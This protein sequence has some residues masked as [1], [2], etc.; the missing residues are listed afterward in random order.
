MKKLKIAIFDVNQTIFNLKEIEN[1]FL[2]KKIKPEFVETWFALTLKEGFALSNIGKFVDFKTIALNQLKNLSFSKKIKLQ[3]KTINFL[4]DG[5][6]NLKANKDI[7]DAFKI[8]KERKIKIVT[9][10]N[11][12]KEN[13]ENLLKKNN[14]IH[15]IDK[16]F[17]IDQ[18]R[19]WKPNPK[20]YEMVLNHYGYL[21]EDAIM[22]ACHG[23]D[24]F[25]AKN[26]G[27]ITG[28]S[29]HYEHYCSNYYPKADFQ[30]KNILDLV[31]NIFI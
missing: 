11:G 24:V 19:L 7:E 22:I 6:K 17:S 16:C 13:C 15:F 1:R 23:W 18:I 12:A 9:L 28:Y 8:L 10:S 25:G 2:E 3:K 31:K 29:S 5:F 27:L 20:T 30:G 4:F 21:P 14:L 26:A